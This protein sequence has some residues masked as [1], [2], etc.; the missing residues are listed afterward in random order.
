[1]NI[2]RKSDLWHAFGRSNIFIIKCFE[3]VKKENNEIVKKYVINT[4]A[5]MFGA[6]IQSYRV[7]LLEITGADT[8]V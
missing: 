6:R 4:E 5:Y 2:T 1:M 3:G 8:E 7:L